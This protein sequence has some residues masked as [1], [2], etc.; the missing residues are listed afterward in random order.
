[1][2]MKHVLALAVTFALAST[3]VSAQPDRD[4]QRCP[5]RHADES[6]SAFL[7][8]TEPA[9]EARWQ[10]KVKAGTAGPETHETFL[11]RCQKRCAVYA[12]GPTASGMYI[13]GGLALQAIVVGGAFAALSSNDTPASP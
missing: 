12:T 11:R 13:P 10:T 6:L 1:M 8:R 5:S 4:D 3:A 7:V 9:C 2:A